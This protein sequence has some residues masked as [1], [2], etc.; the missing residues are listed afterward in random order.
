MCTLKVTCLR[1]RA[2]RAR[3]RASVICL[4][5]PYTFVT[6]RPKHLFFS[7]TISRIAACGDGQ[8]NRTFFASNLFFMGRTWT[9]LRLLLL[10]TCFLIGEAR[11]H[12]YGSLN[13]R[14]AQRRSVH[15]VM[16]SWAEQRRRELAEEAAAQ[17]AELQAMAGP[18]DSLEAIE[19]DLVHAATRT[20]TKEWPPK[21]AQPV[22][23]VGCIGYSVMLF[24]A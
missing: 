4:T 16:D 3:G 13:H 9:A 8:N 12:R 24:N 22:V 15:P 14:P 23:V 17:D 7:Q 18:E 11:R 21:W 5:N 19:D 1:L 2:P 10:L 6:F 20:T